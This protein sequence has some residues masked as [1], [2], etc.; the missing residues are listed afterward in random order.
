MT[1][2]GRVWREW[3]EGLWGCT[4]CPKKHLIA[5]FLHSGSGKEYKQQ[6]LELGFF[7]RGLDM[8]VVRKLVAALIC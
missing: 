4:A 2:Q 7:I 3:G 1:V 6:I 8:F 5:P